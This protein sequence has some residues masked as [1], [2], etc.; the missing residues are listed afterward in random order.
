[1]RYRTPARLARAGFT[2]MELLAT[3]AILAALATLVV[4]LAK[5]QQQR[6]KEAQLRIALREIRDAIDTYK[7]AYDKNWIVH[8]ADSS[9]FPA[10]LEVLWKGERDLR[11]PAGARIYFIRRIPRDPF[12][13]DPDTQ[14]AATWRLRSYAS[15]PEEP[16]EGGDVYDVASRSDAVGLNGRQYSQW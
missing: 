11:S 9:G 12:A 5:V 1:M 15:P 7:V 16:A 10:T 13:A 14:D 8:R 4:P 2:L 6:Q 3:L